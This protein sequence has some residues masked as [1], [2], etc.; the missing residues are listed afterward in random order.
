MTARYFNS[1]ETKRKLRLMPDDERAETVVEM[2]KI[3]AAEFAAMVL[4]HTNTTT[5]HPLPGADSPIRE[6]LQD[7]DTD[8]RCAFIGDLFKAVCE[9]FAA[10][11]ADRPKH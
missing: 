2:F 8:A 7:L 6:A 11:I 1:E 9:E 3:T 10:L 4:E 5:G